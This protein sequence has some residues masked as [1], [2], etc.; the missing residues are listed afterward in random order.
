ML[1][2]GKYEGTENDIEALSRELRERAKCNYFKNGIFGDYED[3]SMLENEKL[4]LR[5]YITEINGEPHPDNEIHNVKWIPIH[6]NCN[7]EIG[8]GIA[9]FVIPKLRGEF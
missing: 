4:F 3:I 9:K 1:P 8:S 6:A 2:G 5:T 7:T